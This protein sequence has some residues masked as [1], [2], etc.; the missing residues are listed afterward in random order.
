MWSIIQSINWDDIFI[1]GWVS[2]GFRGYHLD[3]EGI[4][5][6]SSWSSG[7]HLSI[8]W[9]RRYHL[10]QKGSSGLRGYHLSII[11][12]GWGII[13][14]RRYHLDQNGSSGLREYHLD[15]EG[16]ISVLYNLDQGGFIWIERFSSG[17][18]Y[19]LD[20]QVL[21]GFRGYHL[22]V[23]SGCG[24]II[25][26]RRVSSEYHLDWEGFIWVLGGIILLRG[27]H[28][29]IIWIRGSIIWIERVSFEYHL[30]PEISS[31]LRGYH[32]S[33]IWKGGRVSSGMRGYHLS[34]I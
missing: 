31:G 34:I 33:V 23:S 4:I 7:Y 22:I 12:R 13:W 10:D 19:H 2:S 16:N 21:P 32:L 29:S 30:Y 18:G 6:V 17:G 11:W 9:I 8:I 28:L 26:I 27:Y 5:W 20:Q 24:G 1:R 14:I 25:F 3:W 15:W